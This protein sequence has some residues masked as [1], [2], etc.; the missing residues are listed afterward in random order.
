MTVKMRNWIRFLLVFF[1]F[2]LVFVVIVDKF[3]LP[4]YVRHGE[5]IPLVDVRGRSFDESLIILTMVG[6]SV[7]V[8]DSLENADYP[9]GTVIDQQ[10]P[11]GTLVKKGRMVRVVITRGEH[12]FTMPN[13]VGKVLKAASLNLQRYHIVTDYISYEFS[14]DKPRGVVSAQSLRPGLMVSQNDSISLVV[15]KGPPPRQLEV[16]DLF[17]LNLEEAKALIRKEGFKMG[18]IRY[19]PNDDLVAYTVIEQDPEYGILYDN[20]VRINLEVTIAP[21]SEE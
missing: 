14:S 13:L 11:P 6:F 3:V 12:F 8:S 16:P 10:P 9:P 2:T 4:V 20:P 7:E 5:E 19:I 21:H 15:S 1:I 17:G 18:T